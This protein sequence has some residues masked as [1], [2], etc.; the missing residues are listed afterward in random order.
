MSGFESIPGETPLDDISGLLPPDVRTR[1]RLNEVEAENILEALTKYLGGKPDPAVAPFDLPWSYQ[2][3]AEMFGG[4]WS[5]AGHKRT[6]PLN[7][8]CRRTAL[9][10]TSRRC[11][12]I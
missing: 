11:W 7:S 10:W 8:A 6:V 2:L 12:T 5:W 3:H 1:T 9:T 4:V